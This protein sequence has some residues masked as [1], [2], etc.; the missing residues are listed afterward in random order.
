[1]VAFP[2]RSNFF[3]FPFPFPAPAGPNGAS[4]CFLGT[5]TLNG[6]LLAPVGTPII[7]Y[8]EYSTDPTF[9][10]GVQTTSPTSTTATGGVD[11]TSPTAVSNLAPGPYYYRVVAIIDP[12]T[13]EGQ[14]IKANRADFVIPP[15]PAGDTAVTNEAT[16]VDN[17][18]GKLI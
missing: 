18:G 14:T 2:V 5:G 4:I 10:T 9:S 15:T 12:G 13:P 17:P 1:M 3:A 16:N 7:Y 11:I 6:Y 8:Y